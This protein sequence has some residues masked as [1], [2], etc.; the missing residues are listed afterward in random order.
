M[1]VGDSGDP[2]QNESSVEAIDSEVAAQ[3]LIC[4]ARLRMANEK[5]DAA[6]DDHQKYLNPMQ[7]TWKRNWSYSRHVSARLQLKNGNSARIWHS[8]NKMPM[9]MTA[10]AS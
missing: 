3:A 9:I 1:L 4:R 7:T 5:L 6:E 10:I 8:L 2:E